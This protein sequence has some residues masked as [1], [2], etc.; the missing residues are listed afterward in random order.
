LLPLLAGCVGL[1]L[2]VLAVAVLG[3]GAGDNCLGVEDDDNNEGSG[4]SGG[5]GGGS[6]VYSGESTFAG[7]TMGRTAASLSTC[8]STC[9]TRCLTRVRRSFKG[10]KVLPPTTALRVKVVGKTCF[11]T[12]QILVLLPVVLNLEFPQPFG[13][14]LGYLGVFTVNVDA[15]TTVMVLCVPPPPPPILCL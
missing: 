13:R 5:G 14:L 1:L 4:I 2:V 8:L 10:V 12:L 11:V 3:F 15:L 9:L 7:R 6:E